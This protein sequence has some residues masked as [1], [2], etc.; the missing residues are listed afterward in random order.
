MF[1]YEREGRFCIVV[2][3]VQSLDGKILGKSCLVFD[4]MGEKNFTIDGY[5]K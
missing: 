4:Y 3:K 2:A 5:K 1:K